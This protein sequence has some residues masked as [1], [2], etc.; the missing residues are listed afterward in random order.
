MSKDLPGPDEPF[1]VTTDWGST[2][3]TCTKEVWIPGLSAGARGIA[4]LR[5]TADHEASVEELAEITG[6][7]PSA[8]KRWISELEGTGYLE[9]ED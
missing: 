4:L 1:M 9:L 3:M 5:S 8:V 7:K 2:L 6:E